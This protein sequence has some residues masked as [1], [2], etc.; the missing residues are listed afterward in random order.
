ML[1]NM[2]KFLDKVQ[3]TILSNRKHKYIVQPLLLE[4]FDYLY[5]DPAAD[6]YWR[7]HILKMKQL[8]KARYFDDNAAIHRVFSY[9]ENGLWNPEFQDEEKK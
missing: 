5:N 1:W 7:T 4:Y 8:Y 3:I 9:I 2:H 6:K